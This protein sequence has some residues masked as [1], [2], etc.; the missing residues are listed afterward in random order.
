M[1][2]YYCGGCAGRDDKGRDAGGPWPAEDG[3]CGWARDADPAGFESASARPAA[4]P[5]RG[6]DVPVATPIETDWLR[7]VL[8][9]RGYLAQ[10]RGEGIKVYLIMLAACGGRPDRSVTLSLSQ[11]MARTRL[12]CPTVIDSLARLEGLGLVVSTT[13]ERGKVKTYYV[14]DPPESLS[15]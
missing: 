5:G 11:L 7:S 15:A 10:I 1:G 2:N 3:G 8:I 9:D 12:S 13:H 4:I 6:Y 14:S